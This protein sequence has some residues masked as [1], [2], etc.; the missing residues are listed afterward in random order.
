MR[1]PKQYSVFSHAVE[2]SVMERNWSISPTSQQPY[3][4]SDSSFLSENQFLLPNSSR[5]ESSMCTRVSYKP[6]FW[7]R[8]YLGRGL[9]TWYQGTCRV[10]SREILS[11][12]LV[13]FNYKQVERTGNALLLP[14]SLSPV[15]GKHY[16]MADHCIAA[17]SSSKEKILSPPRLDFSAGNEE[18][19]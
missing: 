13:H 12:F 7:G 19:D 18:V 4:S 8:V 14:F 2:T 3:W 11:S 16:Y 15:P 5:Q 1:S 6:A 9:G 10:C 17:T